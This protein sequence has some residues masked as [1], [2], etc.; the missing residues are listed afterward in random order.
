MR[1]IGALSSLLMLALTTSGASGEELSAMRTVAVIKQEI[2]LDPAGANRRALTNDGVPKEWPL[3]SKGGKR[4]AF[5]KQVPVS[6]TLGNVVVVDLSGK[7]L[8]SFFVEPVEKG[9]AYAGIRAIESMQWLDENSVVV[10]GSINPSQSQYYVFHV[11]S[12]M[13]QDFVDDLS[14]PAISLDGRTIDATTGVPHWKHETDRD[15]VFLR[16]GSSTGE[17]AQSPQNTGVA[18]RRKLHKGFLSVT[19]IRDA[20]FWCGD[21]PLAE[22]P[23]RISSSD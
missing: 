23:R 14:A 4:I 22:L 16:P 6:V 2:V 9:M 1:L 18:L 5:L 15:S 20:D 12:S 13:V 8:A 11:G 21:C 10:G 3:W 17:T 7:Q 19:G